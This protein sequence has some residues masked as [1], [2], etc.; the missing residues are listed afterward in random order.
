MAGRAGVI[1]AALAFAGPAAAPAQEPLMLPP[2]PAAAA[3]PAEQPSDP[4]AGLD[5]VKTALEEIEGSYK[6]SA[7]S[8]DALVALKDRLTPVRD[9]LHERL[10]KLEPRL[11]A[12]DERAAELAK[13]ADK[14]S[15]K[16]QEANAPEDPALAA[17]RQRLAARR[18]KVEAA[19][20]QTRLLAD[21]GH[22]LDERIRHR[23]REVFSSRLFA[24]S[25]SL[26]D[27]AF[28]SDLAPSI[29]AEF[30]GLAVMLSSW[31]A[32]AWAN[33]G[34]GGAVAALALLSAL[35]VAVWF[36]AR[37]RRRLAARP[38]PRR[39]D[40]ALVAIVSI[41]SGTVRIPV[42]TAATVMVLRNF[43]LM[44]DSVAE[45]G[46]GLAVATMVAGFGR[47]V[48]NG[49]FAPGAPDRR[50]VALADQE[51]ASYASHLTWASR[52][53]GLSVFADEV[54]RILGASVTAFVAT[55]ELLAFAILALAIHLLR[56]AAQAKFA[57]QNE[58]AA[59]AQRGWLRAILWLCSI[60]IA[61]GLATSYV[62]FAVFVATRVLAAFAVG[63][64]V[65]VLI[66]TIDAALTDLLAPG[67]PGGRSIAVA[68]GLTQRGLDLI[69]TLA[70]ALMRLVIAA[71]I[72][73][74]A[75]N[76][77]GIFT[78]DIYSAMQR[79]ASDYDVGSLHISPLAIL[80][81]LACLVIGGL[82][83]RAAQRWM[84]VS[85]L[86]R[87]GLD[88]G[89]QNSIVALS[90]YFALI[91]VVAVTLGILGIDLQK[92]ALIAGALSVGIGFGLQSVVSNFVSG[93]ILLAE[94]SIRVGDW[95][96]VKNEEGFV[97]RISIRATEIETF[98][99]ASVIIPNQDFITGVVKNW[100]H[101]NTVGRI[102][103]KVRVAFDSDV[104]R[105]R[106]LLL[107]AAVKHPQVLPG[108]PSV[109]VMGFGD[110]GIDLEMMCLIG[111]VSQGL[112]VRTDL[113]TDILGKF[114]DARI[115]IPYPIHEAG[116][117]AVPVVPQPASRIA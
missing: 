21:H 93:L 27:P 107:E 102:T 60:A 85:F 98:D 19:L 65:F 54:H 49:L 62:G 61:I 11:K 77:S 78:D 103:I 67:T 3:V 90:G 95:V 37:W 87:T 58:T 25:A 17:E 79:A 42:L 44:S 15:D 41:A 53:C 47:G 113:Y 89:L 57:G 34:S 66:T 106:E 18:T 24:R 63:G 81:A 16:T 96:V 50:I 73:L 64:A 104:A 10:G 55:S 14:P 86:P 8:E 23:R 109:Y 108:T 26:F 97:R 13:T 76:A 35:G 28:W 82:A 88:A 105:V 80:S 45:I 1:A 48:A 46:F 111:N 59:G 2:A 92:I 74:L 6:D 20:Q 99:R 94:R 38:T 39:F 43:G 36:L 83:V 30:N 5:G 101:S 69:A 4:A 75:L 12:I 71:L 91:I 22:D 7:Q 68:F 52:F 33:G 112:T 72:A 40:K 117:P 31:S 51:A 70:S 84:A 9:Q 29:P 32:Y 116:V 115:R 100:T 114:R 56:R 110:I